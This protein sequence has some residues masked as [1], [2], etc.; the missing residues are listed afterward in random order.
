MNLKL[1]QIDDL[2][3]I[4]LPSRKLLFDLSRAAEISK[5]LAWIMLTDKGDRRAYRDFEDLRRAVTSSG[6][7]YNSILVFAKM[8]GD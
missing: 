8:M 3:S 7:D 5:K 4:R 1:K 2:L 6:I